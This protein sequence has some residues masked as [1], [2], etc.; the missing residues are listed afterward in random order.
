MS[1]QFFGFFSS[2]RLSRIFLIHLW[3]LFL[4]PMLFSRLFLGFFLSFNSF[5]FSLP[6]PAQLI[7]S[8]RLVIQVIL[9]ADS[10]IHNTILVFSY[11]KLKLFY[12]SSLCHRLIIQSWTRVNDF[13]ISIYSHIYIFVHITL[14]LLDNQDS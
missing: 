7:H 8:I 11:S 5:M 4:M 13:F 9:G 14:S 10:P 6:M 3:L 1:S 2:L 12:S